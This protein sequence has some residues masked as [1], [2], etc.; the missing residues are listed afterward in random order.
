MAPEQLEGQRGR[1]AERH[2]RV[3]RRCS[4]RWRRGEGL[5]RQEPGEPHRLDPEGHAAGRLVGRADDAARRSTASSR[6]ASR[7]IPTTASRRPTTSGSSSSGSP[8][9]ARRRACP[10]RSS[11]GG[12]AASDSPGRSP[13][14]RSSAAAG[15]WR[16]VVRAARKP[17]RIFRSSLPPPEGTS[18]WLEPNG[19]G[20][21]VVSP[22]GRQ[23][24]FTA[25]D[26]A[27]KVNLYV[28]SLDA[29]EARML[30]GAEGAMYPF[31][32]P[33]GRSLG[34]FAAGKLKTIDATGGS[35]LTLCAAPE[36]KGRDLEPGRSHRL[37]A[38][39]DVASL[40]GLRQGRRDHG[41]HED[42]RRPAE[43]TR[44]ATPGFSRTES[45]S[46]TSRARR[47]AG[48][49]G[50]YVVAASV[51]GGAE[52]VLLRSPAA[53]AV[54]VGPPPLSARD[55]AHGAPVRPRAPRV[56]GRTPRRS[57]RR[58]SCRRS[59]RRSGS[60]RPRRTAI[61]VYQTARGET[62]A[63]LQWFTRDGKPDGTLGEP[64]D[65]GQALLSPDGKQAAATIRDPATGTRRPLDLRHRP[66]R[67][68]ALHVRSR[69][70]RV[71]ALVPGRQRARD[72]RVQPQGALRPL[73]QGARRILRGGGA[74]R[75]GRRQVSRLLDARRPHAR[76][77]RGGEGRG[78]R[79]PDAGARRR[80]QAGA[81]VEDEVQ[82]RSIPRCLPTADGCPTARTNRA[83]G[84]STSRPSRARGASGR[85]R[86]TEGRTRSGAPTAGRSSTTTSAA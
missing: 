84:R 55:D 52:K 65:F 3:R 79:G 80:P 11:S 78:S 16:V 9:A 32:S 35:P 5:R 2:L 42:R 29:R 77:R 1:R 8:R 82:R 71:A 56:H 47:R 61:L 25:A 50:H 62:T 27:G 33:D 18:F 73:P 41:R 6:R 26:A 43:T 21:V 54:R 44:T 66:R 23:V 76:L 10:R 46:S 67:A 86:P 70:R 49:E 57:P 15:L 37:H 39:P 7:R 19:P 17:E 14:P 20:P 31:W 58:S 81:L 30:S 34:F 4:S 59:A 28:R 22:D 48:S 51:D 64:A 75:V 60:F 85:S 53:A 83:G 12:G 72:L 38:R 13:R 68:H 74:L 63:R 45:T 40:Q 24:A 36:G 69:R